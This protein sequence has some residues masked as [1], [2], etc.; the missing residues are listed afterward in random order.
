M[1][2][3]NGSVVGGRQLQG[4]TRRVDRQEP[5][6]PE[7]AVG[8]ICG[9]K[10]DMCLRIMSQ[11]INGIGQ[12]KNSNKENGIKGMIVEF[13][14]DVLG[15]QELN[16]CWY[17]I[18]EKQRIW[19]RLKGWKEQFNLSVAHNMEEKDT[20][21][22]QPGGTAVISVGKISHTWAAS[23]SDAWKL[24]RW[25]WT[26]FQGSYGRYVRVV[27]IYRPYMK[28][29]KLNSNYMQQYRY[30]MKKRGGICPR[31]LF[32]V[33]LATE[34]LKWKGE[35]DSIVIM[36]DFNEDIR[37]DTISNWK[38]R[39]GLEDVMLQRMEI[40]GAPPPNTYNRG[41]LPIDTILCS[42][43]IQVEQAGFLP[44]GNGVGDHRPLFIDITIASSLGVNLPPSK[45]VKARRLKLQDPRIVN[46]YNKC[47]KKFF[48]QFSLSNQALLL[49]ERITQPIN[50]EDALE[51]EKL[52]AIRIRGM[53]FAE[54]RCRKLQM[55]GVP[56]TP[57]LSLI[58]WRIEVW[59]LVIQRLRGCSVSARTILR[60]KVKAKMIEVNT[61]VSK[62]KAMEYIDSLYKAY[63]E[64]LKNS[65]IKRQDFQHEL[66]QARA[67]EGRNTVAKEIARMQQTERQRVSA[68][69]IRRM[70]GKLKSSNGLSKV[71][72]VDE[73]GR[74]L[75][76]IDKG[77]M[78]KALL[79]TYEKTLTQ[80]N[81]TPC[82][83]SPLIE[84]LGSCGT[85]KMAVDLLEG[86]ELNCEGV[87]ES[88]AEV[89]KYLILKEAREE[90]MRPTPLNV[91]E[92]Q[93]GWKKAVERTSS[94]M[95]HGTHFGH[96]KAGYLDNDIAKAHT[97][98][99]N[100]AFLSGYSP[101]RWKFGVNSLIPKEAG[102][103]NIK[104]LRTIL[105]YE[106]DFNF[107][108]KVLGRRMMYNAERH[109][110]LAPEQYG[111]RKQMTAIICALNKRLMFDLLRQIKRP[112]GICSCDLHSC[113]DRIIHSFASMA[114]QRAGAPTAAIES[115]F[116]TI[117]QLKHTVR[118][119]HGDSEQS[120]GGEDWR[121]INPLHG[122]GQGNGAGP[123]IWAVIS[124]V[125]FDLLRDKGYGFKMKAPLSK[126]ALHLAGCGFVDD[127]DLLQIGLV[128]DDYFEVAAK[129]QE[130]LHW[131]EKCTQV[132]G[133]A[134]VPKKSWYGLVHFEW[135]DGEWSYGSDMNDAV[136][137]VKD[138]EGQDTQLEIL[139]PNE[140]KRML[141][142]FL[143][144]DGSNDVQIAQMRKAADV[145]Y[146][147]V[148][149]GHLS[150]FD[151]WTAL[152]STVMKTL[153]Y[154]LLATTLTGKECNH[155][156]APILTGGLTQIGICRSMARQL[157]YAPLKY[158]GLAIDN[159]YTTQGLGHVT[160][161]LT[162]IWQ[163]T[164][165]GKLLRMSM[166]YMKLELGV[167]GSLFSKDYNIYEHLV[168]DTWIKHLWKFMWDVG[169]QIQDEIH[170]FVNVREHDTPLTESFSQAYQKGAITKA[171]WKKA[172]KCRLYLR[173]LTV[174]D[175]ASGDGCTIDRNITKGVL[176][177]HRARN[178]EWPYQGR[179]KQTDW[180]IWNRVLKLSILDNHYLLE[181][182]V[183]KWIGEVEG[184]YSE[185]WE[186]WVDINT[187]ALY[188]CKDNKWFRFR[189]ITQRKRRR[190]TQCRYKHYVQLDYT[191]SMRYLRRSS[192]EL[193]RG[194]YTTQGYNVHKDPSVMPTHTSNMAQYNRVEPTQTPCEVTN[195]IR[196]N[197][198]QDSNHPVNNATPSLFEL[199]QRL[200]KRAGEQWALQQMLTTESID[201]IIRD[202]VNGTAVAVS[203][204][205][206]KDKAGTACW[207][208]ENASGTQRIMGLVNVPGYG[209][210]HSAY[211][212]EIAGIYGIVLVIEM[213]QQVWG[214]QTGG[215][216]IGC[217]GKSALKQAVDVDDSITT[218]QHQHF[219]LLSGIQGYIRDSSIVYKSIHIKGHQD[220]KKP[221]E[222]LDRMEILNVQA[223]LY[224][225]DYW[226][227][228]YSNPD[229]E[230][231]YFKYSIPKG[232][233]KISFLGTRVCKK[234]KSFLRE[235]I[236]GG[237]AAEYWV[238]KRKRF[239]KDGFFEVDWK[240]NKKAMTTVS[241][242]KRHWLTKFESG[243]CGT[244]RMMK[245]WKQRVV[246]NCPRCGA[247]NETTTHILQC[248][249][250]SACEVW[251][252]SLESLEEWL[253][254]KKTCPDLRRLLVQILN[255][256][257]QGK[258]VSDITNY[259]F[260]GCT[261][262]FPSQHT[263][264]WRQVMGGCLS[265]EWARAQDAY[266]RW[267]GIRRT[268]KRWLVAVIKKL[269]RVSWDLWKDRNDALHKTPMIADLSGAASLDR[270]IVVEC[271]LGSAGLPQTVRTT[272]PR[273]V[274]KLLNAPLDHKKYWLV[275]VRASRELIHDN[276]IHDEF[277]DPQS[278]L[279]KWVGL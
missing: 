57:E 67:K 113:Y 184:L 238:L 56:W 66:A 230:R 215:V 254:K 11:N 173:V 10:H 165:T 251:D 64:Y 147:Q 258:E 68:Q 221:Y 235:S 20:Q 29:I 54:K 51:Y 205:S 61:N 27:S 196:T 141:G 244:G 35:G 143:T 4:E 189:P 125:F 168:E 227:K 76:L 264:G 275:L 277:T 255:Q 214:L 278:Y 120:F 123:A 21:A 32:L 63:K 83:K 75:E 65:T 62:D 209:S 166:E 276:R 156:M 33:D 263:I 135:V 269:W 265:L 121:Q 116:S 180:Y 174:G 88:T 154:P 31:E 47:L 158:Q 261:K 30:S 131:W 211:R 101:Q 127:T 241:I 94:A 36:G 242:G 87:E 49:Q 267:L 142:V 144:M 224:A 12:N 259:D 48:N 246:D 90:A 262:V 198:N 70:N 44:F 79:E 146:E 86:E 37:S 232:I 82:M 197:M 220:D 1:S 60:K 134:L 126:L 59:K 163:Q 107:N 249:C 139:N 253:I 26:R 109:N 73:N 207:I 28:T 240:A 112:A 164:T 15:L 202:L 257:R 181:Q 233:W 122:V 46:K 93:Q 266:F 167:Q 151:A 213:I 140:A 53:Q 99:A 80:A 38:D 100:V 194:V 3:C 69:R 175:V 77:E 24:G 6:R 270:A 105:L 161:L 103:Y 114:M 25:S 50:A 219:D 81:Y 203:D 200:H 217:D 157:V 74:D 148:R 133:G 178:I 72:V 191:P 55:G 186:W 204:G 152:Q 268:G 210:D 192:V 193:K 223:D 108:N 279:R 104:R 138:M 171:E 170:D 132:S 136:I 41:H 225:K 208:I 256:W 252:A 97:A 199:I 9:K 19:D 243:I 248:P 239:S 5:N 169:I 45:S 273:D 84:R 250:K 129:L 102:N 162:H 190:V 172:N 159:L 195:Q 98:L 52:D 237:E 179:P 130:A 206:Y 106:A 110:I 226:A 23:G 274:D 160:A 39:V 96:W 40:T 187:S 42:P 247:A 149:V 124:T 71:I 228:L 176:Q 14:V 201:E 34:I 188:R 271:Q 218:C 231:H 111:S 43:G 85:G 18:P 177:M 222:K 137:S 212:S 229:K 91:E 7:E 182:P 2:S 183:G 17:K 89:L 78:E 216:L 272:F 95:K 145:W 58:R 115:M 13:S 185:A 119:C 128:E 153:Q 234:I 236:E 150:R 22:Y 8:D 92:C 117:Q 118:T 245:I 155:I 16:V 260:E